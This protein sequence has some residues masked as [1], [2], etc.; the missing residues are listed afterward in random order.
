MWSEI[1]Y[2]HINRLLQLIFGSR[3]NWLTSCFP[4]LRV[5]NLLLFKA[6][7]YCLD[8]NVMLKSIHFHFSYL[9]SIDM[10]LALQCYVLR[11]YSFLQLNHSCCNYAATLVFKFFPCD[12]LLAFSLQFLRNTCKVV[13]LMILQGSMLNWSFLIISEVK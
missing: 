11:Y 3:L 5:Q 1:N 10:I 4:P 2:I 12:N 7:T 13:Q 9:L 6:V 8:F